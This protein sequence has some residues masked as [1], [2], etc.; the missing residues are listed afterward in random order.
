M[1]CVRSFET[2]SDRTGTARGACCT[3]IENV[4]F[5]K[6]SLAISPCPNDT[7]M[8][9]AM[10]NGRID[11]EGLEFD[12]AFKDIEELNAGLFADDAERPQ[13]SKASYAVMPQ[14]AERYAA[15]RSGSALGRGNGPLLVAGDGDAATDDSAMRIA[16]P[17]L[18]TTANLLMERLFPHLSDKRAYL[19]SDIPHVVERGECD[20]GVLIHEGR[21]V[22]RRHGLFLLADL[23]AEWEKATG[24]PL[25][26]G[27]IAADRS[28]PEETAAAVE[29]VLRRSIE[30]AF[31]HPA[32]SLPFVREHA[33]EMDAGVIESH[34]ALFVNDYSLD[35]GPQGAAAAAQL[36]GMPAE[37]LFR[38]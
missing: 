35:I 3:D 12:V 24:L 22:Y 25:P 1:P 6:L 11:T 36:L 15:L 18:H 9:D 17:G 8:F 7:F 13:I 30:Y 28:L 32:D 4:R 37:A 20:A 14:A 16:V 19:F 10:L 21:F 34:I 2:R 26:L 33:Q 23:G 29:R 31:A 27:V 5:M 38:A